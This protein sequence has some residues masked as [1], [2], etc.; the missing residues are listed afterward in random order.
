VPQV[1]AELYFMVVTLRKTEAVIRAAISKV[2]VET[3]LEID[4]C[5]SRRGGGVQSM[6]SSQLNQVSNHQT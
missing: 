5:G 4:V 1:S 2:F 3:T 6:T